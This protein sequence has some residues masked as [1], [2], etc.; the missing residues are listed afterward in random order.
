MIKL[1]VLFHADHIL[2]VMMTIIIEDFTWNAC[3]FIRFDS[4]YYR[5]SWYYEKFN[6]NI[7]YKLVLGKIYEY[8][9]QKCKIIILPLNMQNYHFAPRGDFLSLI[10]KNYYGIIFMWISWIQNLFHNIRNIY[11]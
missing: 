6:D 8:D 1:N 2:W 4:D 10:S 3:E 9:T 11:A 7:S 5:Y